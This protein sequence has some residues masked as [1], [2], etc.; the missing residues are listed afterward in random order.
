MTQEQEETV[1]ALL[2]ALSMA[3]NSMRKLAMYPTVPQSARDALK[4]Q[5]EDLDV[6]L[7]GALEVF[8]EE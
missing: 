7:N 8:G 5:A 4:I 3:T 1:N 6:I 2:N